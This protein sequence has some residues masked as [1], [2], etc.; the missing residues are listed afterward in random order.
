MWNQ[1]NIVAATL[2]LGLKAGPTTPVSMKQTLVVLPVQK[3]FPVRAP[4][5]LLIQIPTFEIGFLPLQL[6]TLYRGKTSYEVWSN[7]ELE[8]TDKKKNKLRGSNIKIGQAAIHYAADEGHVDILRLLV[9]DGAKIDTPDKFNGKTA[10]H[11]AV[12]R[13]QVK[14]AEYLI[15]AGANLTVKDMEGKTPYGLCKSDKM[16]LALSNLWSISADKIDVPKILA[17]RNEIREGSKTKFKNLGLVVKY[18]NNGRGDVFTMM[19]RRKPIENSGINFG[20]QKPEEVL[21]D[22]FVYRIGRSTGSIPSIVTFT[23]FSGP[24]PKEE[25][26]IRSNKGNDFVAIDVKEKKKKW[27]CKFNADLRKFSA[28][29]AVCRPKRETFDIGIE[30]TTV[31]S[32]VDSRVEIS[33]PE[34]AFEEPTKV[35]MEIIEPPKNITSKTKEFKDIMSATSFYSIISEGS[36]PNKSINVIVPLPTNYKGKG[37][38]VI[39]SMDRGEQEED[40]NSWSI[41]N[42]D[43]NVIDDSIA[44]GVAS[45][46]VNIVIEAIAFNTTG[47]DLDLK[48]Q[49]SQL[50]RTSR[51]REHSI[52]F[53]LYLK[54]I[55]KTNTWKLAIECCHEANAAERQKYW[56]NESYKKQ[57]GKLNDQIVAVSKEKYQV[58]LVDAIKVV[59]TSDDEIL[60]FHPKRNNFQQFIIQMKEE[61]SF[62]KGKLD[63]YQLSSTPVTDGGYVKPDIEKLLTSLEFEL[64]RIVLPPIPGLD[65]NPKESILNVKNDQGFTPTAKEAPKFS[66]T[67]DFL[68][69]NQMK[70]LI[71]K[72]ADEWFPVLI[73]M[74]VS[75]SELENALT[76]QGDLRN[77]LVS[78]A[79][80]W[81]DK[82]K[83]KEHLGVPDIVSALAKGGAFALS[84]SFCAD[85]KKW[86][87]NQTHRDDVF[88]K[89]LEKAYSDNNLLNPGDYNCP[90]SDSYLAIISTHLEPSIETASALRLT[91]EEHTEVVADK[92]YTNNRLKVMKLLVVFRKKSPSLIKALENL[93]MALEVL[94]KPRPKKW[95]TMCAS[96][97]VKRTA[98]PK[99]AFRSQVD[100]LMKKF[101]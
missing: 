52:V 60:E 11:H 22:V 92:A 7:L 85:L 79:L 6:Q 3:T 54:R 45:S 72:L 70:Q 12:E 88:Y 71:S 13:N 83:G 39:F 74:G 100:E 86:H 49:V 51:Q 66:S 29:V 18:S 55:E 2:N 91:K 32:M 37:R 77:K 33:I 1:K 9:E 97:W 69:D 44:L 99:D 58:K 14:A 57:G 38:V 59:G 24:E 95:A 76:T 30:E 19:C 81:R 40:E 10:L 96:A 61:K 56:E 68:N 98:D 41:L 101:S 87:D 27:T 82:N 48:Q 89:W 63:I 94:N 50:F 42:V 16:R 46:S 93:I 65:P 62:V 25:V 20:L 17:E 15:L 34:H 35:T 28:F 5:A 73:L 80:N 23:L 36:Q 31:H 47:N 90:M 75:F 64:D 26:V 78:L 21:S 4:R 43:K 53:L 84:R 67:S 8:E